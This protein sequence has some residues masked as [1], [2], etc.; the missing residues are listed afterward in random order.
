MVSA[1]PIEGAP[2]GDLAC[3]MA[4]DGIVWATHFVPLCEAHASALDHAEAAVRYWQQ[5]YGR[6]VAERSHYQ[7]ELRAERERSGYLARALKDCD[8]D[9]LMSHEEW[10]LE[11]DGCDCIERADAV[12]YALRAYEERAMKG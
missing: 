7:D 5:V 8:S 3:T 9:I 1:I 2:P 11:A 6:A 10:C 4:H 12:V